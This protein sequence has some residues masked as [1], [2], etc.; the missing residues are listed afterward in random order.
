MDIHVC[1]C[2][3]GLLRKVSAN[4][5]SIPA[6]HHCPISFMVSIVAGL[7]IELHS[8]MNYIFSVYF[9]FTFYTAYF[10]MHF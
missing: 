5:V 7:C 10:T 3:I 4:F 6:V 1:V 9:C 8:I 2:L